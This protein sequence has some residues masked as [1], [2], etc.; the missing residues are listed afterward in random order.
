MKKTF[1]LLNYTPHDVTIRLKDRELVLLS[2]GVC[3]AEARERLAFA[4]DTENEAEIHVSGWATT[5]D[6]SL[7]LVMRRPE[8]GSVSWS[9]S[10]PAES[11]DVLVS[12]VAAPAVQAQHPGMRIFIPDTGPK[13]AIRGP[14]GRITAIRRLILWHEPRHTGAFL[15]VIELLNPDGDGCVVLSEHFATPAGIDEALDENPAGGYLELTRPDGSARLSAH[16]ALPTAAQL[17]ATAPPGACAEWLWSWTSLQLK[18]EDAG[19]DDD[20]RSLTAQL[21]RLGEHCPWW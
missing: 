16:E 6:N 2:V 1:D 21:E 18:L 7:V 19:G 5:T 4:W 3:R 15:R 14:D 17:L 11:A 13:S 20:R 12:V 10:P 8:Y 9:P